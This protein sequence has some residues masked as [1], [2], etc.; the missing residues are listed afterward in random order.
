MAQIKGTALRG[1]LKLAK[2][3]GHPGGIAGALATLPPPLRA[4][5]DHRILA[6]AWYPYEAYAG[7][8]EVLTPAR[9]SEAHLHQLGRLLASFDAGTTFKIVALFASVEKM[10]TRS[11]LFWTQ[12]CDTGSFD[13][14]EMGKGSSVGQL[15]GFP[16]VSPHHCRLLNGWIEGMAE[17]AGA[18]TA[19]SEKTRCVHRGDPCC[20]YRGSWQ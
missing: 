7:L 16:D 6:S 17:A 11:S 1:L 20:E 15:R 3:G 4:H 12:H 8:L 19:R 14:V 5:F 13:T 10:L 9:D 18:N 2:D